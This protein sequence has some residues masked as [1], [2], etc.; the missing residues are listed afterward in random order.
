MPPAKLARIQDQTLRDSLTAAHASLR[1]GDFPDVVRRAADAYLELLRRKPDLLEGMI[2][3]FRVMMFP[4]L[5]AR[6]EYEGEDTPP[7]LEWDRDTF[8]F[9]EAVT[10]FEFAVDQLV[11][12]GL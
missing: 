1:S 2:G 5:G 4:R 6:M 3:R 9:S 12:E 10:Y 8:G 11:R 7:R